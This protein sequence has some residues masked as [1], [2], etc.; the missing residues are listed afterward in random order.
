MPAAPYTP[1]RE[2][3]AVIDHV[4][5]AF[6]EACP[7]AGKTR[8][9]VARAARLAA[10][11]KDR[12]GVAFL[13]FTQA[14]VAELKSR[15]AAFG[16]LSQ[17]VFPGFIGTFDSFLWQMVI[18]PFGIEGCETSPRLTPDTDGIPVQPFDGAQ[19]L[20]LGCFDRASGALRRDEAAREGFAANRAAGA[21]ETAARSTRARLRAS[22]RL[23]FDDARAVV[24]ERLADPAFA[25][26]LGAALK[27]RFREIIVDEAQDCNAEDLKIIRWM[28][29]CGLT[30]S[31]ICDPNQAIYEFRGGLTSELGAFREEF[32]AGD[33][34]PMS[35]NFRSTPAICAAVVQLRPPEHRR[36][37]DEAR[38]PQRFSSEPV[39]LLSY[40]G[41][42]VPTTLGDR[43][44]ALLEPLGVAPADAPVVASTRSSA[45]KAIGQASGKPTE[46]RALRL[47][48]AVS[49]VHFA[50]D[51]GDRVKALARLHAVVCEIQARMTRGD[52][53]GYLAEAGLQDG[54][55]RP[56]IIALARALRPQAEEAPE[57]WLARARDRLQ[58]GLVGGLSIAQRLP[59]PRDWD[60]AL[61]NAP[62]SA[63][64]ARTVH[65]VKGLEFAAVCV[66]MTSATA[67]AILDHLEG[68]ASADGEK[69]ARR[70]YVGASR[71]QRLLA[72]AVPNG[73]TSRLEDL[74]KAGGAEV[75]VNVA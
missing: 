40:A 10:D 43:F 39:H 27:G 46:H 55:W 13:S 9:L 24:A 16:T 41:K 44:A 17:P 12:R 45:F 73:F 72:I 71:A 33:R 52:Y 70:I 49:D 60:K 38:E 28:R 65:A 50:F 64:P 6:V 26:R 69:E 1:T 62:A 68:Q 59:K 2:Q 23:D 56:D 4:G 21:W 47:A 74:F 20:P 30:V 22:G 8:T 58:P 75:S 51:L 11:D 57:A 14:A 66:V 53:H 67:R 48:R 35:G 19:T 36:L 7:G 25:G 31:V 15:L 63:S 32:D 29:A 18:A 61:S 42:G 37:R 5:S 34:L 54:A 3:Q